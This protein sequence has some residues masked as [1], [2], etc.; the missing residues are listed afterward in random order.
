MNETITNGP[1]TQP[2]QDR[3]SKEL[4]MFNT[5]EQIPLIPQKIDTYHTAEMVLLEKLLANSETTAAPQIDMSN[6]IYTVESCVQ[7]VVKNTTCKL[8][9][10]RLLT[11]EIASG[12]IPMLRDKLI[13]SLRSVPVTVEHRHILLPGLWKHIDSLTKTTIYCLFGLVLFVMT[14][15][16]FD[17]VQYR[18]S[19]ARW[20][21]IRVELL[22]SPLLN[23][24]ERRILTGKNFV[25]ESEVLSPLGRYPKNKKLFLEKVELSLEYRQLNKEVGQHEGN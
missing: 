17:I 12:L 2:P 22:R 3:K 4:E 21:A 11:A 8:P 9:D 19:N 7:T 10:S 16:I 1:D 14:L 24:D 23:D 6:L 25:V 15:F 13:R 20:N 5:L 18:N